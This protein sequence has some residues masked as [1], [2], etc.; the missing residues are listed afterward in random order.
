[1]SPY[2]VDKK[3]GGD[4]PSNDKWMEGCVKKVI[5]SGKDKQSAI[6][7]CKNTL[8]KMKGNKAKAEFIIGELVETK[9]N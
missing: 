3:I 5:A 9:H 6:M 1:M 8:S 4:N 2:G 7:I